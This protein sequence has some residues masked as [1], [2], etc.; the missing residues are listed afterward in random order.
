MSFLQWIKNIKE[1][2]QEKENV[3][4][5]RDGRIIHVLS[6]DSLYI[7]SIDR[8]FKNMVL[9]EVLKIDKCGIEKCGEPNDY[10]TKSKNIEKSSYCHL[11]GDELPQSL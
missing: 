9:Y 5:D 1:T 4:K 11:S 2:K 6:T 3:F 8:L 7:A 10:L